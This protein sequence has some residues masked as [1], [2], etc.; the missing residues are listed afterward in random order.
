MGRDCNL[1]PRRRFYAPPAAFSADGQTVTL[2]DNE[3]H[4]LHSV[5]RLTAGDEVQVFDG[6]GSEFQCAVERSQKSSASLRI[7]AKV[8]PT[9]PESR[10]A[11]TLAMVLLKGEKFDLVIQKATELGVNTIIPVDSERSDVR[12]KSSDDVTKRMTRWDRIAREAAKQSGRSAFPKIAQPLSFLQLMEAGEEAPLKL[13]FSERDGQ[14]LGQ[15]LETDPISHK[16]ISV[17]VGPEG[18]WT[19]D[20][21]ELAGKNNWTIV[22]LG[23]RILRA[24]TAAISAVTLIQH[25]FGD[26][27]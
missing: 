27:V 18:G 17:L 15:F 19:D 10:L 14:S 26:L 1:M 9:C 16:S 12:I 22:T 23:G 8:E 6:I 5:L 21:I 24:E 4:H 11:L 13:M 25:R 20:E 3:A 2:S 7:L